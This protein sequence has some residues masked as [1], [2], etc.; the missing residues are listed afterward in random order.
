[1]GGDRGKQDR[2]ADAR[3]VVTQ[4]FMCLF[5]KDS[6]RHFGCVDTVYVMSGLF[7]CSE[8]R[9]LKITA[10]EKGKWAKASYCTN[11]T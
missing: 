4:A 2:K 6:P 10:V 3:T 8:K 9:I 11:N 1:M 7:G 5:H